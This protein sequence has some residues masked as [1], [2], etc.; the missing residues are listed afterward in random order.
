MV[1]AIIPARNE[2]ASIAHAVGSV[3]TQLEVGEVIVVNDNSTDGTAAILAELATRYRKLRVLEAGSLP[4]GWVGKNHAAAVGAAAAEGDWLLFTDADTYHYAGSTRRALMDAV[5]HD[6]VLVSYSPEQELVT[7]WER[8]L[9]P[10]IYCRLAAKFSYA[11][12]NDPR[13]PEAAANGQYLLVFRDAY[14]AVGGHAAV[15]GA[16]LE[17]VA[18]A[19][20]VKKKFGIYFT[21]PI[22]VVRTRM[23]GSF[24]AMWEGW[25]K[26][27]Y[28]LVGGKARSVFV[29]LAEA[30]PAI[31]I[32]L[33][34]L[35]LTFQASRAKS[36]LSAPLGGV[37]FGIVLGRLIAYAGALY[38]NLYPVRYIEYYGA[39]C[40][41]YSAALVVSWWKNARG[42]VAWKG[43]EYA[44][45]T[46]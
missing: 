38:R 11:R 46:P 37:L 22:G 24:G 27:L 31:E 43:R 35:L 2:E 39:S 4:E 20:L 41:L 19:Q 10:F 28:L 18:L 21:A 9:I 3:A 25:T 45:K 30:S 16:I 13:R 34:I 40:L 8:A 7:W 32:A 15:A 44:A 14:E 33:L 23:Y 42:R 26:N 6:A 12:V 29:E 17:D 36:Y 1:S 5:D